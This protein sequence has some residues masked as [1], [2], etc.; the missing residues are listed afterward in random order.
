MA[1]SVR[2]FDSF[3]DVQSAASTTKR[4]SVAHAKMLVKNGEAR[5]TADVMA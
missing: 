2:E 1:W 4:P 5:Q 3:D